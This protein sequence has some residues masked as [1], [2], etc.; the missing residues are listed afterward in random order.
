MR[1]ATVALWLCLGAC[2]SRSALLE[3]G[4]STG[5]SAGSGASGGS[6]GFG[7]GGFGGAGFGGSGFGGGGAGGVAGFGGSAGA[8]CA[9]LFQV[10]PVL[11]VQHSQSEGDHSPELV[12]SSD[13]QTQVSVSFL[14]EPVEGPSAFRKMAHATLSPW[15]DWPNGGKLAPSYETFASAQLSSKYR[16]GAGFGDNLSLLVAHLAGSSATVSFAPSVAA[17]A[18]SAG[19]TVTLPGSTPAFVARGVQGRHLVGTRDDASLYAHVVQSGFAVTTSVLGCAS[20]GAVSDA[21]GFGDGWV[22]ALANG[23]NAPKTGCGLQDPGPP[24]RLDL[25]RVSLDGSVNFL[26]SV[27]AGAPLMHVA[28]APHP[29]GAY[30]VYR[31]ASGGLVAPIRWLR[32]EALGGSLLGP[33]D[34]SGPGDF[35][36]EFDAA[37]LGERLVVAWGNDPA[38]NP[39]DLVLSLFDPLGGPAGSLAF[40]PQFLGPVSVLGAPGGHGLVVAW[41]APPK[42]PGPGGAVNL[43]RFDCLGAL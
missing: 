20:F 4:A 43:A 33:S 35:P 14:R 15:M 31:V 19:P 18:S 36:L 1:A 12:F 6:G 39:P 17:K 24:S 41:Q 22:V 34:V 38:G 16:A 28:A 40:E 11:E 8:D 21:V 23:V 2:G 32:V 13:D 27:D 25:V 9:G 7:A 26:G 29:D 30:V 42:A 10:G 5:G 3:P 37:A